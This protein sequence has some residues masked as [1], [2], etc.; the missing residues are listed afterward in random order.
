V[1]YAGDGYALLL[2]GKWNPSKEREFAG[3][4]VRCA[5]AREFHPPA[6]CELTPSQP[7]RSYEDNFDAVNN[8]FVVVKPAEKSKIEVWLRLHTCCWLLVPRADK[9]LRPRTTATRTPF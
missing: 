5:A 2:P 7:P 9:S 6:S 4:D 3:M 8:L 1:P